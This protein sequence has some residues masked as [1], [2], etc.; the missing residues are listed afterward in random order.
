MERNLYFIADKTKLYV[1]PE[2]LQSLDDIGEPKLIYEHLS[3]ADG[4]NSV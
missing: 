1:I 4:P 3:D 2:V